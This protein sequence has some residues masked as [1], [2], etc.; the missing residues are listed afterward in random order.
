[1]QAPKSHEKGVTY[2]VGAMLNNLDGLSASSSSDGIIYIWEV[3]FP[4]QSGSDC[5]LFVL[6]TIHVGTRIMVSLALAELP[7]N[8]ADWILAM[9]GLDNKIHLYVNT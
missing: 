1:L 6:Q 3:V 9:E 8:V 4:S 5:N 7:G 2:F